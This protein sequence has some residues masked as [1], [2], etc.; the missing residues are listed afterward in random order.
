LSA[1]ATIS[2]FRLLASLVRSLAGSSYLPVDVAG[3]SFPNPIGLAAGMDKNAV[4]PLGW[5]AF[6]FM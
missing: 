1:A 3:L 5:A 4:A 6:G 2:K